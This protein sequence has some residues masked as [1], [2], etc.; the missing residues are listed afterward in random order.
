VL[1]HWIQK[2]ENRSAGRAIKVFKALM[3]AIRVRE[4]DGWGIMDQ[5]LLNSLVEESPAGG[6]FHVCQL[7]FG[8][9]RPIGHAVPGGGI[10][11]TPVYFDPDFMEHPFSPLQHVF[12]LGTFLFE[13]ATGRNLYQATDGFKK[14]NRGLFGL[15]VGGLNMNLFRTAL[16]GART[17]DDL[18]RQ[19]ITSSSLDPDTI[20]EEDLAKILNDLLKIREVHLHVRGSFDA[21][22]LPP[23]TRGFLERAERED[24][25]LNAYDIARLNRALLDAVYPQEIRKRPT[26]EE[27]LAPML[28]DEALSFG[29]RQ[30][31][32]DAGH[33]Q[34]GSG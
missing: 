4:E 12:A 20:F 21:E 29:D 6:E 18:L 15:D 10:D 3:R 13:M 28:S 16:K 27:I 23:E 1:Y 25:S 5:H 14:I 2:P 31:G 34:S 32:G 33:D 26:T 22:S 11:V 19:V 7:D 24:A 30:G 8:S 9:I 17:C